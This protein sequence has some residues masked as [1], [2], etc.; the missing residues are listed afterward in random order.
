[1]YQK[2]RKLRN[3]KNY[4][5]EEMAKM[6]GISKPYYSQLENQVRRLSYDMAIKI[7]YI[8]DKKPDDIFYEQKSRR[9]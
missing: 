9:S 1:M 2:L 8:F 4:T 7:A 3:E 6:L 5:T